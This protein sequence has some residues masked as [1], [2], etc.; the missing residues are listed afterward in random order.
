LTWQHPGIA[1]ERLFIHRKT[2]LHRKERIRK[3]FGVDPFSQPYK[4]NYQ[5]TLLLAQLKNKE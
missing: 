1:S 4:L 5:L 3:I 2:L